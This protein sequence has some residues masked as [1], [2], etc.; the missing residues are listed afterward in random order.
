MIGQW[1]G[2][3]RIDIQ[4]RDYPAFAH[5]TEQ[6]DLAFL[7]LGDV[8]LCP[9]QQNV[10]LNPNRQQFLHGMLRRFGLQFARRADIGQQR[11]MDITG[12]LP[13]QFIAQLA[14]GFQKWQAFDVANRAAD[15]A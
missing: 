3:N 13:P 4:G 15:F 12:P 8:P 7:P 9:T 14:D 1:H 6:R 11:A 5:V 2:I 10:W